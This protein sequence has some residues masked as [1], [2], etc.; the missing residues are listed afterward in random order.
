[1]IKAIFDCSRF[2]RA[3]VKRPILI[4]HVKN[5]SRGHAKKVEYSSTFMACPRAFRRTK[6][7]QVR[8]L[9]RKL[10]NVRSARA[11]KAT[12]IGLPLR[13]FSIAVALPARAE[14]TLLNFLCSCLTCAFFVRLNAR[15][16]AMEVELHSTFLA[17]PRD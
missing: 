6:N 13:Q 3:G 7:A 9:E 10:S 11:G 8:Q 15:G 1:M 17:C 14:R 4:T 16:H 5:Q 2:A 12:A